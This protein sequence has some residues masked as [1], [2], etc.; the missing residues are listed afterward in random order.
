M[1]ST[2]L[3][4][5]VLVTG[6]TGYIGSYT[7]RILAATHPKVTV[8]ALSRATPEDSRAKHAKMAAFDNIVF[9]QGDCLDESKLPADDLLAECDSVIHMVGSITDSFNY[10]KVL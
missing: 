2:P 1:Q 5:K 6:A 10:K 7:S 8:Y 4:K 9:V 3:L